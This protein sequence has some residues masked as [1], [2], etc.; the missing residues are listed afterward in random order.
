VAAQEKEAGLRQE[1]EAREL[2]TRR[3]AYASDMSLAQQALA[4]NDLG[5]ARR[6]LETH[7]PAPGEVDLRGWEWRYLWHECRSDAIDELCRYPN[8][9]WR[10]AFSS[11]G[12][13]LGT[14]QAYGEGVEIWHVPTR[15]QITALQGGAKA[16]L[17][18]HSA[19]CVAF[20]PQG[21]L[22][23]TS[24]G[25]QV[26]LWQ[27]GTWN[28]VGQLHLNGRAQVLKFSPDGRLLASLSFPDEVTVWVVDQLTVIHHVRGVRP[29]G[30]AMGALDF[31][32]DGRILLIGDSN[33]R[34]QAI[35]LAGGNMV[36]DIPDAHPEPITSVAWSPDGSTIASGSGYTLGKIRLWNAVSGTLLDTLEGHTHYVFALIF[37][38]DSA[39]LYS[40]SADQTIRIWD[41]R[42]R[43]QLTILRGS[44]DEVS[45]LALSPDGATLASGCKDGTVAFWNAHPRPE[46]EQPRFVAL[47]PGPERIEPFVFA[48]DS[49]VVAALREGMVRLFDLATLAE[50]EQLPALGDKVGR[51]AYSPDGTLLVSG[52]ASGK[53]R[54]W[55]CVDRRL[56][57]ELDASDV[58]ILKLVFQ[59]DSRRLLSVDAQEQI[60]LWDTVT[61]RPVRTFTMDVAEGA[62]GARMLSP[63]G[64][65][66][67]VRSRAD[68]RWFNTETGEFLKVTSVG[69]VTGLAFSGDGSRVVSVG[70]DATVA[71]WD[72][73]SLQLIDRFKGHMLAA[74]GVAFSSDSRRFATGGTSHDSVKLWDVESH[75]E[76][77]TLAGK[78]SM[79][80][81]IAFSPDGRWLAACS[82]IEGQ[83]HLWSAPSWEEI[84]AAENR[85]TGGGQGPFE[86]GGLGR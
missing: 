67:A 14:S 11:D 31:S 74:H 2:Y 30:G 43:Q 22:V 45:A 53:I 63:D 71:I 83:L 76:V 59:A 80:R 3:L 78:G 21:D 81:T 6:L 73:A 35:E 54:V 33:R 86:K 10:L 49:R 85:P 61:W 13:M 37:S 38:A 75:R 46:Q 52:D 5:R 58:P 79:F 40:S 56:L 27:T 72:P 34:L 36:F 65:L 47:D 23:A 42:Q 15:R 26:L 60:N 48:P 1:A 28:R 19:H 17:T 25:N 18:S 16:T 70:D 29:F 44:R 69:L 68:V 82:A 24:S 39:W 84:E 4:M 66:L 64:R 50:I 57:R 55:S 8:R 51:L 32:P 12:K 9:V 20:S 41:V 62:W 7:R 77:I